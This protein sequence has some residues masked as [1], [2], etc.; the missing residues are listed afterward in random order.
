[1]YTFI[2]KSVDEF[3]LL[4]A[5]LGLPLGP[6]DLLTVLTAECAQS[7][8]LEEPFPID[9][10]KRDSSTS[11]CLARLITSWCLAGRSTDSRK[12][13]TDLRQRFLPQLTEPPTLLPKPQIRV[14]RLISLPREYIRLLALANE[15]K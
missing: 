7:A 2:D 14:P 5:Y 13:Y 3:I 8:D 1:M 11:L 15:W 4:L 12:L 6:E 10:Q 9:L